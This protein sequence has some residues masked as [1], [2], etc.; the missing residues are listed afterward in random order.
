[1]TGQILVALR[2]HDRIEELLPY[3]EEFAKPGMRVV[4][5]IH[6]PVES[7]LWFQDYWVTTES[8]REAMLAGRKILDRYSWEVQ[9]GL[10]EQ[11]VSPARKALHKR[12]VEMTV[13]L[14]TGS[15]RRAIGD[16][17][18]NGNIQWIMTRVGNGHPIIR[19]LRR[20]S[21]LFG[22]LKWPSFSP[23]LLL[24][25]DHGIRS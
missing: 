21:I 6:Y 8:P 19:L 13:D 18:A 11:R 23:V 1:M 14:Y 17:A 24:H 16:Y 3:L 2:R 22:I 7:W 20:I 12:E 5:L 9:K 10:A 25:P 15:L 4:F